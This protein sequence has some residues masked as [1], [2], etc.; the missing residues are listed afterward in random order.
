MKDLKR[1]ER[2]VIW[3]QLAVDRGTKGKDNVCIRG[4]QPLHRGKSN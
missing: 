1:L 4:R 3:R 2:D